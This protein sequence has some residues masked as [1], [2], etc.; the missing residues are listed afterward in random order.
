MGIITAALRE[1]MAAGLSGDDLIR[2]IERIEDAR[3]PDCR[4]DV[5]SEKRRAWDREY[6]KK[7]R[8]A[9]TR[10]PPDASTRHPPDISNSRLESSTASTR[11][12]HPTQN[13]P[14]LLEDSQIQKGRKK[15][16]VRTS[17]PPDFSPSDA[18]RMHA[19]RM[20]WN[21]DT[22]PAEF[23]RWKDDSAAHGRVYVDHDA[24]LRKWL[25]SP[26]QK[27]N[28]AMNGQHDTRTAWQKR[29]DAK[30]EALAEL[31]DSIDRIK[32]EEGGLC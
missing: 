26:L 32:R 11:R 8:S 25:S 22:F 28:G 13:M 31:G 21:D 30:H 2:S 12:V 27:P 19:Y 1:L 18:T 7:R 14:S 9:S 29:Q 3:P 15:E 24:A 20:G 6:R 4:V 23:Q 10:H 5:T 16:G 17:C